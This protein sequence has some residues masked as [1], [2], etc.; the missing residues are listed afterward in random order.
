MRRPKRPTLNS[1][2]K[3]EVNS[4]LVAQPEGV[5]GACSVL[6][7]KEPAALREEFRRLVAV[8][9][10][11]GP[12]L[13]KMLAED[14]VLA[15]RTRDGRTRLVPTSTGKGH[16]LWLPGSGKPNSNSWRDQAICHFVD[17]VVNP[18]WHKLGGPCLRCGNYYAKKTKRQKAYCSRRCGTISTAIV[19]TQRKRTEEHA[20]K[21]N[22]AQIAA[23]KWGTTRR[24]VS[25][26]KWVSTKTGITMKWLSRAANKGELRE[27]MRKQN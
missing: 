15:R 26:K 23:D 3:G 21:L 12:N 10:K 13:S 19:T 2:A 25:W 7:L 27:P 18:D 11:S 20:R 16:L 22:V 4:V 6:N 1:L 5:E 8:W 24:C 9:Q 17:L 14:K